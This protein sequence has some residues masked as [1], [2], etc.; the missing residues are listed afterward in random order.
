[1]RSSWQHDRG[2]NG[3]I[4]DIQ[5]SPLAVL[6]NGKC[7]VL[8]QIGTAIV[9]SSSS[10][11]LIEMSRVIVRWSV[12]EDGYLHI[13]LQGLCPNYR[14]ICRGYSNSVNYH[15]DVDRA[16][17]AV[18][19]LGISIVRT[20]ITITFVKGLRASP[21]LESARV[22]TALSM[23][24][25]NTPAF[26]P[27]PRPY[28]R[29]NS[30]IKLRQRNDRW[31]GWPRMCF[32]RM[33]SLCIRTSDLLIQYSCRVHR[34][35]RLSPTSS[36]YLSRKAFVVDFRCEVMASIVSLDASSFQ[37]GSSTH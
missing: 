1:M 20:F 16:N 17:I 35:C 7:N 27:W 23:R 32:H 8:L 19:I 6:T 36:L 24:R 10:I 18:L 4:D 29:P 26:W 12:L 21:F 5:H 13:P 31:Q 3:W 14:F 28:Y 15:R 9:E 34:L 22:T 25:V 2:H 37:I 33:N 30:Q 11:I